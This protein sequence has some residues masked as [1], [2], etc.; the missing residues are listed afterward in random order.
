M[1]LPETYVMHTVDEIDKEILGVME[2]QDFLTA[3]V[4]TR[5]CFC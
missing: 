3:V 1:Q 5:Q 2:F 4:E